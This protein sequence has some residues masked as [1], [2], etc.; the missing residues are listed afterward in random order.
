MVQGKHDMG[1]VNRPLS[2][3][4]ISCVSHGVSISHQ[5]NISVS[6]EAFSCCIGSHA[7]LS[8]SP[9]PHMQRQQ[10][11]LKL[12]LHLAEEWCIG[13]SDRTYWGLSRI[14]DTRYLP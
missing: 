4:R 10:N 6:T 11:V 9:A 13:L 7:K 8:T 14:H 1:D 3:P 5:G 2:R 12:R